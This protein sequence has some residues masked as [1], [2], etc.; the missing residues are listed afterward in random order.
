MHRDPFLQSG[1][2][3]RSVVFVLDHQTFPETSEV[4]FSA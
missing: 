2:G 3:T 1:H 4:I